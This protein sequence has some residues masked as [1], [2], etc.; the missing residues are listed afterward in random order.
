MS[1][2]QDFT[3]KN[4]RHTG[5][6]GILVSD[7][8]SGSGDRVNEKGRLRFNDT[9]DLLEYYNGNDWKSIDAPPSITGF[10]LNDVGGSA[11]TSVNI[12][13]EASG[14]STIEVLG[15][16]F[17]T[18]NGTI[19]FVGTAENISP[20]STTRNSANKFTITITNSDFDI[21]NSPYTIKLTNGS[22][23]SAEVVAAISADQTTPT[24]TNAADTTFTLFDSTRD[25]GIAAADLCGAS[26]ASSFAVT[27]GSLPSGLS[28]TSSTGAIT[29][30]ANAVGSDTTSTF[31]VTATGDDATATRQFKI[32]VKAPSIT[33]ITSTGAGNFSVPTGV[34][35][36][37]IMMVAG[38]GSGGT[39]LGSG[40][41]AGGMLEGTLTVTPGSTI[42]YN[43][44]AGGTQSQG[45]DYH[46]GY[47]GSNTTFGPIPG[48][49]ATAT[50]VGGGYGCGHAS[51][52]PKGSG[53]PG[54]QNSNQVNIGG[55]G[56]SS[57][58]T[59]SADQPSNNVAAA[60]TIQGDSAGLTGYGNYGGT[61][62]GNNP[63][64][65][66]SGGGGG[67][68]GGA[69]GNPSGGNS[70]NGGVGRVSNITGSPVYYAGGGGGSYH[71]PQGGS[72]GSGGNGGGTAG[73]TS[74]NRSSAGTANRGGG[75]GC[76]GHPAGGGG[77]G[78]P[79][80]IVIKI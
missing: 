53:T 63:Q 10:T 31:T 77:T 22:G 60:T 37:N 17:D 68:A 79:G 48:P 66:H 11:V 27:T 57:G 16:L 12:D 41:G 45:S 39:S 80:I 67:G 7:T 74:G 72:A 65:S 29:G 5:T 71:P 55:Q 9:S 46:S 61:G 36:L 52:G 76:G 69:G 58:G 25:A 8:G 40:A 21:S 20:V 64:H 6:T 73:G 78:G 3:Q 1:D 38:G 49:G 47:Y 35:S 70:G 19:T 14:T 13:N 18:T 4:R 51:G 23:L 54:Q 62:G 2:L 44:G 26:G 33:Q 30:T 50:A 28:M 34:S 56:G 43:V 75:T 15:S 24:F 59:G 32:T 42:A